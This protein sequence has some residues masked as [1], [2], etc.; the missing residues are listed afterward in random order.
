MISAWLALAVP[1]AEA[2]GEAFELVRLAA[3]SEEPSELWGIV[4]GW[5]LVHSTDD[6]AT[7]G[8]LCEE[9][10]GTTTTYDLLPWGPGSVLVGTVDGLLRVGEDC[11]GETVGDL[12]EG[13]VLRLAE[14]EGQALVALV[15]PE[16]GGVYRCDDSMCQATSLVGEGLYPKS[17]FVD[18]ATAWVT[19]VHTGEEDGLA[20]E[21]W[22]AD[23]GAAFRVAHTWP[24]G[25]VDPRVVYASGETV[26]A[27]LRPRTEAATPGFAR[28]TDG[29]TT[30]T[31]TFTTGY[32]TDPAPGVLVR[33]EGDTVFLGSWYGARTWVSRDAGV[34]FEE[35]SLEQPA[36]KCGLDLPDRSLICTDHLADGFDVAVT[37]DGKTFSPTLC[38]EDVLPAACAE[39]TCEPYVSAWSAAAAIGGGQ[40]ELPVE[41][42]H[43][44]EEPDC[45]CESGATSGTLIPLVGLAGVGLRRRRA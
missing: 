19:V 18:G 4:E 12:P 1:D 43:P 8:W 9:S 26:Y 42:A 27:W 34:S 5:G 39:Q 6:G 15:G 29:G 16:S 28:S 35:V 10:V 11:L 2:H 22:R 24:A 20:A 3:N 44:A 37:T 41:E 13:F 33:D 7:W 30:F 40:C 23:D 38:L 31:T 45:G 14:Y 36:L 25:D 32:F 21:L 17:L